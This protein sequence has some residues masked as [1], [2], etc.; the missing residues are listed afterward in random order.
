MCTPFQVFYLALGL[1]GLLQSENPL[2]VEM[3]LT[4]NILSII[5]DI[6]VLSVFYPIRNLGNLLSDIHPIC[7]LHIECLIV[8]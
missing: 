1:W 8:N 7:I 6:I 5:L 2:P 3:M 4:T